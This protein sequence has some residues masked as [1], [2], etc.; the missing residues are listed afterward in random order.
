[1]GKGPPPAKSP[2]QIRAAR[3]A[4]FPDLL[5]L[6]RAYYRYDSIRFRAKLVA[7]GLREMLR[8]RACGQMW[9]MRD[10]ER[11][12]GYVAFSFHHDAEFGGRQGVITDLFIRSAYRGRGLGAIMLA[13][14][15]DY[16]R[17][18]GIRSMELQVI[19]GNRAAEAFYRKHGFRR[20][21][22]TIM[23]R[24]LT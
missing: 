24:E 18:A 6:I 8:N 2:M 21:E 13:T 10:G 7:E 15:D 17:L 3:P 12:I 1:M 23:A 22:R 11:A 19:H 20:L 4:D 9:I 14:V 16:C 5:R